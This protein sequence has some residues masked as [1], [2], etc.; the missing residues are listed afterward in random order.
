MRLVTASMHG[1][2]LSRIFLGKM[3]TG[4]RH[5][6]LMNRRMLRSADFKG[7]EEGALARDLRVTSGGYVGLWELHKPNI[8]RGCLGEED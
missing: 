4:M 8:G 5:K 1:I 2:G 7:R 3:S 6:G